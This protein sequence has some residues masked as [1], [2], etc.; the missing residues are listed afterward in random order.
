M[1][2]EIIVNK[3]SSPMLTSAS[4]EAELYLRLIEGGDL[5]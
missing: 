5:V 1:Q 3:G 2:K 4:F